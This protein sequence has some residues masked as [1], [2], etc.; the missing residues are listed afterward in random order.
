LRFREGAPHI[1]AFP[2]FLEDA[3]RQRWLGTE[4]KMRTL[5]KFAWYASA[6]KSRRHAV[7]DNR[8][9]PRRRVFKDGVV[10]AKGLGM[11]CTVRNLSDDGALLNAEI[12]E[13]PE[14]LTLVIVSEKLVRK[15]RVIWRDGKKMGVAFI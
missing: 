2:G 4:A 13:T 12:A 10:Q 8:R 14:H 3:K 15:C 5:V 6:P 1:G 11:A 9:A 7:D